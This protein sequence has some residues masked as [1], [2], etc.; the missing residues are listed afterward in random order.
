[1]QGSP[2]TAGGGLATPIPISPAQLTPRSWPPSQGTSV[3]RGAGQITYQSRNTRGWLIAGVTGLCVLAAGG[4]Y[5][6][7][8]LSR[9]D[10]GSTGTHVMAPLPQQPAS[11]PAPPVPPAPATPAPITPTPPAVAAP[12]PP[13]APAP[14][15]PAT[16]KAPAPEAPS[17]WHPI[18]ASPTFVE[19]SGDG[20]PAPK[21]DEPRP[22]G[23]PAT[24]RLIDSKQ[25]IPPSP[26]AKAAERKSAARPAEAK[27]TARPAETKATARPAE[28]KAGSPKPETKP[29]KPAKPKAGDDLFDSRH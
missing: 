10:H 28:T 2:L 4:G 8:Q 9:T 15:A 5:A 25:P 16:T 17:T 13:P 14:T 12:A 27:A 11:E 20:K 1:M 7:S 29:A 26:E 21:P 23:K 24:S 6:L 19:H 18:T 22:D 3:S